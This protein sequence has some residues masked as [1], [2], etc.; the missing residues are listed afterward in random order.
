MIDGVTYALSLLPSGIVRQDK[1]SVVGNGVVVD[2]WAFVDE[3]SRVAEKG[4][5]VTPDRLMIAEN[6]VLILPLHVDLD[7]RRERQRGNDKIGTTGRGIGPAYEDKVGRVPF[8]LV[9]C[10][11]RSWYASVW[12]MCCAITMRLP[13][14]WAKTNTTWGATLLMAIAPSILPSRALLGVHCNR[15]RLRG[16]KSY[17]KAQGTMLDADHGTYPLS[18]VRTSSLVRPQQALVWVRK[19]SACFGDHQGLYHS[20]RLRSVPN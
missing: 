17:S 9:T 15:R 13:R 7:I 19:M 1:F 8:A 12:L 20:R 14:A 5:A 3:V 2:P 6:A 16:R 11:I 10:E 18:P 4:V